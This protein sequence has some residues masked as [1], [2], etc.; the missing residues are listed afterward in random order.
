[1][2]K[3][4]DIANLRLWKMPKKKSKGNIPCFS[5]YGIVGYCMDFHYIQNCILLLLQEVILAL[6][7]L[8]V[9]P[10]QFLSN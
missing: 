6:E 3:L 8:Y 2:G 1:M 7:E 4:K 9:R 10:Q 5:G